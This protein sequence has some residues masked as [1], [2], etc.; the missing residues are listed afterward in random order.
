MRTHFV[1]FLLYFCCIFV[2]YLLYFSFWFWAAC[3]LNED[4]LGALRCRAAE[5]FVAFLFADKFSPP[6][7]DTLPFS[8]SPRAFSFLPKNHSQP[9][10][11]YQIFTQSIVCIVQTLELIVNSFC[12]RLVGCISRMCLCIYHYIWN[13]FMCIYTEFIWSQI[14]FSTAVKGFSYFCIYYYCEFIVNS[15]CDCLVGCI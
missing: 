5:L 3:V 13:V 6:P 14:L 12:D 15:F 8:V 11:V 4:T 2:V 7:T 9:L 1:A 10:P